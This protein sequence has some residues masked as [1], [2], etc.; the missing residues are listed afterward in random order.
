MAG[1]TRTPAAQRVLGAA[2]SLFAERGYSTTSIAD[3]E[4]AAGLTVGAGGIYRHFPSKLAMLEAGVRAIVEADEDIQRAQPVPGLSLRE[5]LLL[6]ARVGLVMIRS[7]RALIR[8]LYRDLDEVPELLAEV[9]E[10]LVHSGTREFARRLRDLAKTNDLD[11][12]RD[13]DAVAA[14]Y[15]GAVVNV[16]VL[17]AVLD[18]PQPVDDD[19]FIAVFV[20]SLYAYLVA[21]PGEP[22]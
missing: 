22:Q 7:Q 20:D 4:R 2:M 13:F 6:Y 17:E 5:Q 10:R 8:L 11:A 16:G 14:L 18:V 1:T 3:I 21:P 19:R 12:S 15:V 9:K